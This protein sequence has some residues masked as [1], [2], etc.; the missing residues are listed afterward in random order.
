M[1]L[2]TSRTYR[3]ILPSEF[4]SVAVGQYVYCI[5]GR[6]V[7]APQQLVVRCEHC[8]SF[9]WIGDDNE[10]MSIVCRYDTQ[11]EE[12][13]EF[14]MLNRGRISAGAAVLAGKIYVVG[15]YNDICLKSVEPK[16]NMWTNVAELN[17]GRYGH[18][19]CTING[20][21]YAV[22]G[23][24]GT[25]ANLNSIEKY[26]ALLDRWTIV[27]QPKL[28]IISNRQLSFHLHIFLFFPDVDRSCSQCT[29]QSFGSR[30]YRQLDLHRS[31]Q[32]KWSGEDQRA[33]RPYREAVFNDS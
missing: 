14:R 20:A 16:T 2:E 33:R 6:K 15:G 12:W 23:D 27:S 9:H 10:E 21:I 18:R 29:G 31:R 25:R 5:G 30:C 13:H 8:L 32:S 28:L 17:V 22:G 11:N 3:Q 26:D 1:K 19:C 4:V 7:N 24:D